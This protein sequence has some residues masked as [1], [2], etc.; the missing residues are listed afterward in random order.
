MILS[1]GTLNVTIAEHGAELRSVIKNGI[2][3]MWQAD[4]KFWG[5]T[6]PV[7]FPLVGASPNGEYILNGKA[8]PMPQHGFARDCEFDIVE[9]G[10]DYAVF[11]LKSNEDTL[12]IYPY[13]FT[14]LIKYMLTDS[15]VTVEWTVINENDFDMAFSIGAHPAFNFREGMNYFKFNTDKDIT[16]FLVNDDGSCNI[17]DKHILKN[18]GYMPLYDD[19]FKNDA[20]IIEDKQVTEVSLCDSNKNEFVKVS[21]DAPLFGLWNPAKEGVPFVCI[22]PWYGRVYDE[23]F[24]GDLFDRRYVN[25]L[26]P[27]TEFKAQYT[28][29]FK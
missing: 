26:P 18:D 19:T 3:Y 1:N 9:K 6:S 16:Y 20:Y 5:K 29:E 21:F 14:L 8:Y 13:N 27:H 7:L 24:D 11:S 22:E 28:M 17:T 2:E 23:G 25:I 12:K 10:N 15:I 4:P